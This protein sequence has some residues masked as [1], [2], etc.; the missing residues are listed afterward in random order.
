M[1]FDPEKAEGFEK[2]FESRRDL[3]AGFDGCLGVELLREERMS[4]QG[5]VYFTRS[6]WI[7]E[8]SLEKYRHSQLFADTWAETKSRFAGKPEAWSTKIVSS[9]FE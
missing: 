5:I 9:K 7:N 1:I 3:I 4:D 8:E 6:I 2:V